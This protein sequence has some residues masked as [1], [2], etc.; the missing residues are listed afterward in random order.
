MHEKY[1]VKNEIV[2]I[3]TTN[4]GSLIDVTYRISMPGTVI[5]KDMLDEIRTRNANLSVMIT[6]SDYSSDTL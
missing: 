5:P 4:M 2:R 3:K 1:K 6:N